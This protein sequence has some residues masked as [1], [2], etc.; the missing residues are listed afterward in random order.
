MTVMDGIM[1]MN[2]I[3]LGMM[4]EL[5]CLAVYLLRIISI[6]SA[7]GYDGLSVK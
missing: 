4:E 3:F 6:C 2:Y 1:V 7:K 5:I